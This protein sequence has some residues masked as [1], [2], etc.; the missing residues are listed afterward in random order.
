MKV[1]NEQEAEQE[2]LRYTVALNNLTSGTIEK[3]YKIE[4][5]NRGCEIIYK[6]GE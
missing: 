5:Y 1:F 3:I 6:S 2:N 4:Y